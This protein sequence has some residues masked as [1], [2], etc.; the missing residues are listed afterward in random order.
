MAFFWGF[1]KI[2]LNF[3]KAKRAGSALKMSQN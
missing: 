3:F 2:F 1:K